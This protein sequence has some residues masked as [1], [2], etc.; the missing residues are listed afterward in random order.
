MKKADWVM[1]H[2]GRFGR[3]YLPD[4]LVVWMNG[5]CFKV[6][7]LS[8]GTVYSEEFINFKTA[9]KFAEKKLATL[10]CFN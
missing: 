8:T 9:C 6:K 4:K 2:E 7:N 1:K 5:Y 10:K 3:C